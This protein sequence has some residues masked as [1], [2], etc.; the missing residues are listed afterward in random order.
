MRKRNPDD[1]QEASDETDNN[2]LLPSSPDPRIPFPQSASGRISP[3]TSPPASHLPPHFCFSQPLSRAIASPSPALPETRSPRAPP[4]PPSP[5][6]PPL[7]HSTPRANA[8]AAAC[9]AP[10]PRTPR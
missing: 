7:P 2:S 4:R 9:P 5:L 1:G 6:P 10:P 8:S 3:L